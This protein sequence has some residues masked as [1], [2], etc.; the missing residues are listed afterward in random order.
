MR[1]LDHLEKLLRRSCSTLTLAL[2][3]DSLQRTRD[4]SFLGFSAKGRSKSISLPFLYVNDNELGCVA[5]KATLVPLVHTRDVITM[6]LA[7]IG[8]AAAVNT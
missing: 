7:K 6:V 4:K 1:P 3:L 8:I 2:L 5:Y